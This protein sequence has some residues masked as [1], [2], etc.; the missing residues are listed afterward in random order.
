MPTCRW[1][2]LCLF[3]LLVVAAPQDGVDRDRYARD[4]VQYLVLQLDQW[5]KGFP[6]DYNLAL[7][8]PPVDA[9]KM[10]EAAK[11][12][13]NELR[14]SITRL[15]ALTSAQDLITN[16]EFR[17]Q[18]GK[19]LAVAKQVNEAMGKQR[20]PAVLQSDWDQIR[21][22]LNNLARIYKLDALA[23]LEAPGG[24]GG[25]GGRGAATTT[26]ATAVPGGL[27]GYIVDQ[28]CASRGKGMWVNAECVA[29]CLRDGDKVV[30]VTEEGK[31][32]SIAN[33]DKIERDSYGQKVTLVGKT[34]GETITVDS[35]R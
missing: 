27:V 1:C 20:F 23:I 5:T 30:L 25:R 34:E 22:N 14:E 24:G 28:Q 19:A 11:A 6:H 4:Y 32:F 3:A 17:G 26:T 35:L 29:R 2:Y 13:A 9:G 18:M 15:Y 7:V 21:G 16:A 31:I 10:S 8:K 33:P 12:G